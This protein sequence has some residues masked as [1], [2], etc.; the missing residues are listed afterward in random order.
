[1]IYS[2]RDTHRTT[3]LFDDPLDF[4]P[5]RWE[6][7]DIDQDLSNRFNYIPFGAGARRCLG[8]KFASLVL[9]LFLIE[10]VVHYTWNLR[11]KNPNMGYLPSTHP[12][13][14]LPVTFERKH[15]MK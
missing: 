5:E 4:R 12:T 11:N 3:D 1:M 15:R 6:N 14:K 10:L 7:L 9:K 2:I 13:D 8:E